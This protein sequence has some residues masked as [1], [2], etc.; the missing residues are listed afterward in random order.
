[1]F[2]LSALLHEFIF[3][4]A[5]GEVQGYQT[6]FFLIQGLA[7][8]STAHVRVRGWHVFPWTVGTLAFNLLSSVLFFASIDQVALFYAN[9]LPHWL[10]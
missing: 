9:G 7:V 2:A 3:L 8:A 6:A 5:I 10:R 1:V 4:A